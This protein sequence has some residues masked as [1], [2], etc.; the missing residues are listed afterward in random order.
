MQIKN[1]T[2]DTLPL[3][4][5]NHLRLHLSDTET[6]KELIELFN[7]R[8]E[9]LGYEMANKKLSDYE[10][11]ELK[12]LSVKTEIELAKLHT[13]VI[14]KQ[15]YIADHKKLLVK[16]LTDMQEDW[17][18]TYEKVNAKI[19]E[20]KEAQDLINLYN[21]ELFDENWEL[22]IDFYVRAKNFL[23]PT[24]DQQQTKKLKKV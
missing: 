7:R 21:V 9:L 2:E 17:Y 3:S 11:N 20:S 23:N 24:K 13:A 15:N 19:T 1:I 5:L 4:K 16:I 22:A 14:R 10:N 6:L 18:E 8:R 12:I